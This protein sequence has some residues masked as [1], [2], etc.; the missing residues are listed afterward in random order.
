[1]QTSQEPARFMPPSPSPELRFALKA[2]TRSAHERLDAHA[3]RLDLSDRADYL[4]F[5]CWH[6]TLVPE[7]EAHLAGNGI[8]EVVADWP[9]RRRTAALA[10]DLAAL[11]A[12][13]GPRTDI[14]LPA[15]RPALVGIAYVLEGSRLGGA[16]LVRAVAPALRGVATAY[17]DHGA[18]HGL[19]PRFVATINALDFTPADTEAAIGAANGTFALFAAGFARAVTTQPIKAAS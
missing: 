13:G 10:A 2:G 17:L 5:L 14:V 8:A 18:G 1:M 11:G 3:S 16:M 4:A 19:W 12:S 9:E 7:L 15:T 6:G